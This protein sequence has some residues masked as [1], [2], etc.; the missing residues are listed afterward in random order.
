MAV[1]NDG[2][3]FL[4]KSRLEFDS[5]VLRR[6]LVT[7]RCWKRGCSHKLK[8]EMTNEEAVAAQQADMFLRKAWA[9]PLRRP[10]IV[11]CPHPISHCHGHDSICT[12]QEHSHYMLI[13]ADYIGYADDARGFQKVVIRG[14]TDVDAKGRALVAVVDWPEGKPFTGTDSYKLAKARAAKG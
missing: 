9:E 6:P 7:S 2:S 5:V 1:W 8:L 10:S 3:W 14:L 12:A 13:S 4:V 11:T